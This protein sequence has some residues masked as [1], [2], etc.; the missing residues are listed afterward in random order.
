MQFDERGRVGV[1]ARAG[2]LDVGDDDVAVGDRA[3]IGTEIARVVG[4]VGA[5]DGHAIG[6]APRVLA[7]RGHVLHVRPEAV[8]RREDGDVPAFAALEQLVEPE[9]ER[10]GERS[11][12][13]QETDMLAAD[14]VQVFVEEDFEAG[15]GHETDTSRNLAAFRAVPG[16][17]PAPASEP[18]AGVSTRALVPRPGRG[19]GRGLGPGRMADGRWQKNAIC[20]SANPPSN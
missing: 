17:E 7:D 2:V 13:G 19:S 15:A 18:G 8:L 10:G 6:P 1:V 14:V 12:V 5:E 11:V 3:R 4:I 16:L 20:L 9:A